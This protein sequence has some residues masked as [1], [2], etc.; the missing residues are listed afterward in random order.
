MIRLI[1]ISDQGESAIV[2]SAPYFRITGGAVWTG[3]GQPGE[4]PLVRLV[5]GQWQYASGLWAGLRFEGQCRLVFGLPREPLA[6]SEVLQGLSICNGTLTANGIPFAEYN[7]EF[8]MW[9]GAIANSWWHAFRIESA[10]LRDPSGTSAEEPAWLPS[11]P[12]EPMHSRA[13]RRR[14]L[15]TDSIGLIETRDGPQIPI[16]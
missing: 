13:D 12:S 14:R 3:P 15:A 16:S 10:G 11:P 7:E 2:A 6:V 8:E 1:A 9:K 5:G 4:T